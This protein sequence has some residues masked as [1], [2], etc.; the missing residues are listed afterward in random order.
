M[1]KTISYEGEVYPAFQS[2]GNASQ[3]AIPFA[4]HFC[5]GMGVDIGFSKPEWIFPGAI[6]ADITDHT[7]DY[8]ALNL[9]ENLDYVYSSHCLE[10]LD[11]WIKNLR[12]WISCLKKGGNIFLY[13][14]HPDQRYW[15]PW[16]NLKHKH[17]LHPQ[18]VS[19]CLLKFGITDIFISGRDLNHSYIIVGTKN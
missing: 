8:H 11:D 4:K 9:P 10:H 18:D 3:F 16:N 17:V 6:G 12:Y 5:Q 7:N 15:R 13:L 19:S 2:E 14:P 1:I